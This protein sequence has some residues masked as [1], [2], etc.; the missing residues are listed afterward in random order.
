[1]ATRPVL[2]G[3]FA[4]A[5]TPLRADFA[6]D[7]DA[8]A[9][10]L[11]FLARRGCHGALLLGTTGEGPSFSPAERESIW[12]A[13]LQV[14]GQVPDFRLLVG[15]GT[16]SLSETIDLTKLAFELGFDGVVTLPPY[17][18]RT[19]SEAGLF[20]W[21]EKVLT[22]A[23]PSDGVLLGYHFPDVAGI[24]F[25]I[26]LLSRLKEAFPAKF[27]GIKDS[28]HN[29]EFGAGVAQKFGGD[30]T[31]LNGTDSDLTWALENHAAGC[32]TAAAN[33]ISPG[34][35]EV[36]DGFVSGAGA[37]AVQAE[38]SAQRHILERYPPFPPSLKALLS[39]LHGQP[40]WPVRPPLVELS[41]THEERLIED[42]SAAQS[43]ARRT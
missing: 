12:R 43:A 4:A 26:G 37:V 32:I 8:I 14:R 16:P 15:T 33:L 38:V 28:S 2:S 9:P 36:Y 34:L 22:N 40:R 5:V 23:V 19:A 42:F 20:K 6:P 41:A 27:A 29:R 31:V 10:F 13:A 1:M 35:R 17:Y 3:V 18:Y 11:S 7:L 25:S 30:L 39:R 24:G 21:F